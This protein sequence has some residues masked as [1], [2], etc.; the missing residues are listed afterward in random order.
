[1]SG[2]QTLRKALA[3]AM[4]K[5]LTFAAFRTP[6][7]PVQ[8]WAQRTPELE[9]VDG[10]LLLGLNQVF[11]LAAFH[12]DQRH[13]P[14]I[15]A[16]VELRFAEIDPDIDPL[17]ECI[18]CPVQAD[19]PPHLASQEEYLQAV[20]AA[21]DA[22]VKH[23]VS[24]VVLSRVMETPMDL[25]QWPELFIRAME[26]APEHFVCMAHAPATG[27]WFGTSPERLVLEEGDHVRVDAM[28]ATRPA[29]AVPERIS[30]WGEKELD[31]QEQVALHVHATFA[32]MDLRQIVMRGPEV[33]RAGPVAH[34]LTTMEADLGDCLLGDLVLALHPTPATCGAPREDA[35][36]FIRRTERH[37]RSLYAGFW[38]P[39]NAEGPTELFVNL[40][41][42]QAGPGTARL[43]VGGGITAGSDPLQEWTE[44]RSK[45]D[46]LLRLMDRQ[47]AT[48][49]HAHL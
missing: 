22:C 3:Q 33:V 39:W 20:T 44:T 41:C 14:F 8:L 6:G 30:G 42:M 23:E 10:T 12:L 34:L 13:V 28:A 5:R 46:T 1:M 11:L 24:K 15:R 16:D 27:L 35:L 49:Q 47:A 31:E 25:E 45:A 4:A 40:R 19:R 29:D 32:R 18:G 9:T 7:Q 37:D 2:Q 17:E 36:A 43:H 38:G 48:D 26:D 21:K